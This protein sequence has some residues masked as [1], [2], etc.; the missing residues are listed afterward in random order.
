MDLFTAKLDSK[1]C[2]ICMLKCENNCFLQLPELK[3]FQVGRNPKNIPLE[4]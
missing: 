3:G 2:D 4:F 1:L